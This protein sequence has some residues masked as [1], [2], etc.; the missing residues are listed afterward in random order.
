MS[1]SIDTLL[2][3]GPFAVFKWRNDPL[4]TVEYVSP[5]LRTLFGY[6]IAGFLSG[7][8][9][10]TDLIHPE[11]QRRVADEAKSQ[12]R[13]Q[14]EMLYQEYRLRKAD[15]SFVWV[16]DYTRTLR[17]DEGVITHY[18]GYL[19]EI[20]R[21]KK[22]EASLAK[23]G[24]ELR[25]KSERLQEANSRLEAVQKELEA[26]NASLEE[27]T[28]QAL[29]QVREKDTILLKQSRH[30][31]LGE[32]IGNIAHQ[33]RQPLNALAIIVQDLEEA[34]GFGELDEARIREISSRSMLLINY[35]S[36]TIDD[37]RNFFRIE[38][39]K[40]PFTIQE[41][42]AQSIELVE[43]ALQNHNIEMVQQVNEAPLA[44][45]GFKNEF[46]QALVNILTN[47][48]DAIV[49]RKIKHGRIKISAK[50]EADRIVITLQDNGGGIDE[51][52]LDKIFDPY[53]TTKHQAQGTGIGLYMTK[54]IIERNMGGQITARN[55]KGGVEFRIVLP[56]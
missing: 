56:V 29:A 37:F 54:M 53:F 15:G 23:K 55:L 19:L 12:L 8:L 28:A 43:A 21:Q 3:G 31:A 9:Q 38:R 27:R 52:I 30:A 47:A 6:E 25:E 14:E 45:M 26:L 7:Q 49:E 39:E 24:Q 10:L 36:T 5:N 46:S 16:S 4:W 35:L 48:R 2:C 17:N 33:W 44:V 41:A 50:R 42:V 1:D 32:M 40:Q 18:V 11:D 22:A 51:A 20:T 13:A 34:Y